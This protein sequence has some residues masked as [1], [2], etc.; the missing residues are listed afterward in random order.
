MIKIG[1]IEISNSLPMVLIAGPC[2]IESKEH[3]LFMAQKLKEIS[4]S[5]NIPFI[6]KS[7]F[8]KAGRISTDF[9]RGPGIN[10]GLS[11][12]RE[13][14]KTLNIPVTSDVHESWQA[15]GAAT[16]LDILQIPAF[17]C[18]QI[19]LIQ[20]SAEIGLPVNIKKGQFMHPAE[21][22]MQLEKVTGVGNN[23]C[24]LTE[25]GTMCGYNQL[26][27]DMKSFEIMKGFC[28]HVIYD[29]THSVKLPVGDKIYT[30]TIAKA[31]IATGISGIFLEVHDNPGKAL[32]DSECVF[33]LDKTEKLLK[34][35]LKIDKC[36]K[37]K[38]YDGDKKT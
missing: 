27:V 1:K 2:V 11:I 34:K 8:D 29:A 38:S 22:K 18:R 30:E 28:D 19:D 33:P 20:K 14:K 17:L 15:K 35:L 7:S 3:T 13:V 32:C 37:G 4:E 23:K 31:A 21:M 12:L 36:I 25:R 24:M 9:Y 5:L 6:F 10:S 16:V 26:F